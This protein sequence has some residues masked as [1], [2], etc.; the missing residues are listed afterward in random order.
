MTKSEYDNAVLKLIENIKEN[1][2]KVIKFLSLYEP[3]IT[4]IDEVERSVSTLRGLPEELSRC[5][6]T[7]ENVAAVFFPLNLPLYS[8][9][10]FAI[11]PAFFCEKVYVRC[12]KKMLDILDGVSYI[13][14]MNMLF[15]QIKLTNCNRSSFVYRYVKKMADIVL[16]T[17]KYENAMQVLRVCSDKLFILNGS[18]IN[19][20]VV[21]NDAD[22]NQAVD[23]SYKMRLYNG[24]QDCAGPDVF[25]IHKDIFEE[26]VNKII[27]KVKKTICG[28]YGSDENL[29]VG[30]LL[31]DG[32]S[33]IVKEFLKRNRDKIVLEGS[34]EDDIVRPSIICKNI[35]EHSG[36]FDEFFAPIFYILIY[37]TEDQILDLLNQNINNS[38]YLT[39][40]SNTSR[41]DSFMAAT[42]IK[43][44]I[45]DDVEQG[46][47]QYGG[48]GKKANFISCNGVIES[49]PILLSREIDN[50][51]KS[52]DFS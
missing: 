50:Y 38:M 9:I 20:V 45:I 52:K 14:D 36:E 3:K 2:G 29:E 7:Q 35:D 15:P 27:P 23:K 30:P 11:A 4:A 17:G 6:F 31:K 44:S 18:G 13:L 1:K 10:L 41:F 51:L 37:E 34:I 32:Y 33:E 42:K 22:I 40:F 16:F 24:G 12:N 19:P 48:Y 28:T 46:N 5:R 49:R 39:Y 21:C 8:L 25:F 26:F 43:N 47:K